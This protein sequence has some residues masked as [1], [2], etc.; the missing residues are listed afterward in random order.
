MGQAIRQ[1]EVRPRVVG[2]YSHIITLPAWWL[3]LNGY[4]AVLVVEIGL[5]SLII[6]P[7]P[8]QKGESDSE[9]EGA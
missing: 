9:D 5:D 7:K 6:R 8:P 4:P 2:G 3:K 1:L